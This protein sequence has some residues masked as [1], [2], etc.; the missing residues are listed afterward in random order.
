MLL[1]LWR[2]IGW[3]CIT[4]QNGTKTRI[5]TGRCTHFFE[6]SGR[7]SSKFIIILQPFGS[8]PLALGLPRD[9]CCRDLFQTDNFRSLLLVNPNKQRCSDL[10]PCTYPKTHTLHTLNQFIGC[11]WVPEWK[12][13]TEN[14]G[15][16]P[17]GLLTEM[18]PCHSSPLAAKQE[19]LKP[20]PW[21]IGFIIIYLL[22]YLPFCA[23]NHPLMLES[24]RLKRFSK[25]IVPNSRI[26]REGI[27]PGIDPARG[28]VVFAILI[29]NS[30]GRFWIAVASLA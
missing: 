12:R 5:P 2:P 28:F 17:V 13:A 24:K 1:M 11:P 27:G 8:V 21:L 29:T 4:R 22:E 19:T 7:I 16:E 6:N 3:F 14:A 10:S 15:R 25:H 20:K 26:L 18:Q 9:P 30:P 23:S